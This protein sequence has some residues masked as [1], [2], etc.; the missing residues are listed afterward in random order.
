MLENYNVI[1]GSQ[2]PRRN[3]LLK[4][5]DIDFTVKVIP[6][7]EENYP[8]TLYGEEIPIFLAEQKAAAYQLSDKDLLITADTIV[9]LNDKV[10]GKPKSR[11]DA[12]EILNDLSGCTHEVITGVCVKTNDKTTSFAVTT[13][14]SFAQLTTTEIEHYVD[15]YAPMDKAGAYGIQEW[16]G[17]IGVEGIRGS[18]YNVM[19]LPVQRLYQILKQY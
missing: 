7:L 13:E 6:G 1:L 15:K 18:Y 3:E 16:I 14:V 2:S 9:W 8:N 10:Y 12:I 11:E 5:L 19:G 17:Y 4:S